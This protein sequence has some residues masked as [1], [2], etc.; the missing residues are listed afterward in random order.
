MQYNWQQKDWPIFKYD[1]AN[2]ETPLYQFAARQGHIS[3]L[4]KAL[5]EG[6]QQQSL[7][8]MMVAEAL[9]TFEIEG[10]Y[11][12]REDVLSSIRNNLVL[13]RIPEKIKDKRSEGVAQLMINVKETFA[14][15]LNEEILFHWHQMMMEPYRNINK[16]Q[17]R[18]GEAPMQII[19]GQAGKEIIH[20]E[21]PPSTLIPVEMKGFI[22]WFNHTAPQ[23]EQAIFHAPVRSAIT[24]V[25]F[26]SI[27]PFEDGNGRMGRALSEK[28]LSQG[29]GRPILLSLSQA[30]EHKRQAYYDALK[31]AQR[32]NDIT[33]WIFYFLQTILEAQK[34]AELQLNFTLYKARFFDRFKPAL[35]ARQEKA[36]KK[37]F[38][39]GPGG[40]KGGMS[41]KKYMS[42]TKTSKSTA[43]RDLVNLEKMGAI[44]TIGLG[45][46][47][48]YEL[49]KLE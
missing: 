29:L 34:Q 11:L 42:I 45:R 47:T 7:I 21:A 23:G 22:N 27:H 20:F 35:N 17:W 14:Q 26:E 8:D 44:L 39:A 5:P 24:H 13:N 48:K 32:S 33:N 6:I 46:A 25:Y 38:E 4:L 31:I 3:G 1:L 10:E 41:A 15:N 19:S 49:A 43:T 37:M 2:L 18:K 30:I 9:K 16:G 28:A 40:F 12:S 36:L